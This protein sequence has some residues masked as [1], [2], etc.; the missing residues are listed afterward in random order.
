LGQ[1]L[2]QPLG[3]LPGQPG[4]AGGAPIVGVVSRSNGES[5]RL[6]NGRGRYNEWAFVATATA[7]QAGS[8]TGGP[9]GQQG[10]TAPGRGGPP[11]PQRGIGGRT[12]P[13]GGPPGRGP[14]GDGG[15][16]QRP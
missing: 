3:Q 4:A 15:A 9:A 5:L 13:P 14:F 11:N 2:G 7:Q 1:P 16:P 10:P 8:P 12:A 6:Y